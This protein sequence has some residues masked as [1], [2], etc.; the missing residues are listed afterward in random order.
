MAGRAFG[1]I[2]IVCG[3]AGF[4]LARKGRIVHLDLTIVCEAPKISPISAEIKTNIAEI[5]D[6]SPARVSV[7]ATTSEKNGVCWAW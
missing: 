4:F 3:A 5:C 7:K 6:I 1:Y 2:F